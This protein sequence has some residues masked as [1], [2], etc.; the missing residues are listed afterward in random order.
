MHVSFM[1]SLFLVQVM[2]QLAVLILLQVPI[3]VSQ[4]RLQINSTLINL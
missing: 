3:R 2:H 1:T 4:E